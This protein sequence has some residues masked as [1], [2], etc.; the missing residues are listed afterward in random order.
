VLEKLHI[1]NFT[2]IDNLEL[3]LR[4]GF[5]VLSGE[6]GAGKSILID[7]IGLVLGGRAE[8]KWVA[9]GS[10]RCTIT[11]VF[12][13]TPTLQ[14]WLQ[15]HAL[16]SEENTLLLRRVIHAE[17]RS[18]AYI[19]G[20]PTPLSQVKALAELLLCIHGQHEQQGLLKAEAQ[21]EL[22]DTYA[23]NQALLQQVASIATQWRQTQQQLDQLTHVDGNL[24]AQQDL[25]RYQLQELNELA[26]TAGEVESL[27]QEHKQLSNAENILH[28]GQQ[29]LDL[30][31]EQDTH[32][33]LTQLNLAENLI[34][35]LQSTLPNLDNA[36]ALLNQ[37]SLQVNEAYH[38]CK[39][40]LENTQ[41]DPERLHYLE[42]RLD[43]VHAAARKHRVK[44]EELYLLQPQLAKQLASLENRE[45]EV[46]ELEQQL[47]QLSQH[48]QQHAQQLSAKRTH[49]AQQLSQQ[50]TA[51]IQSL[52]M[53]NANLRIEVHAQTNHTPSAHG[54]DKIIFMIQ[55]NPGQAM[56][57][58]A[59]VASG[60][61]LS[62]VSLAIDVHT[63]T[64]QNIPSMIFDEVDTGVSGSVA[65]M[66]GRLLRQLSQ[67]HQVLCVTHLPQVAALAH[68][69]LKVSKTSSG[70]TTTTHIELLDQ[71][72]TVQ[73]IAR[74]LA[75]SKITKASLANAAEL[76]AGVE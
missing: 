41:L 20:Q 33:L 16:D 32:N 57:P 10:T 26:L 4:Q 54:F 14:Q 55:T 43:K 46:A 8:S 19:N 75:G 64:A 65:E 58:L 72:A 18:Q 50:I 17:G 45:A 22:L 52:G 37:A 13:L 68:H 28:T 56:Q 60:G 63:S 39:Q 21:R 24:H 6:T 76:L 25:W 2:I 69:H 44:A 35:Q 9:C 70:E 49:A 53:P 27:H 74:L 42:Q 73:E 5:T 1:Q 23:Q 36:C 67:H 61:E 66:I 3:D 48:Y 7:A 30:L 29:L 59:K 71:E 40:Q 31:S 12:T 11:A 62:R 34:Q 15:T 38:D 51:T 47:Q